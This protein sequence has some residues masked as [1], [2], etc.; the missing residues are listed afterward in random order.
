[1]GLCAST[2][3]T[4]EQIAKHQDD[5]AATKEIDENIQNDHQNAGDVHKL[6]LLGT[7]DS[8]KSTLFKQ[9]TDIFGKGFT[10]RQLDDAKSVVYSNTVN[11]M[12]QLCKGALQFSADKIECKELIQNFRKPHE[13]KDNAYRITPELAEQVKTVWKDPGIQD[14]F[15]RLK[16]NELNFELTCFACDYFFNKIDQMTDKDWLPSVDDLLRLRVMTTG[17]VQNDFMIEG[18]AFKMVDVGG[19]RNERKKWIHSFEDVTAVLFV[20]AI[21]EYDQVLY[22]DQATNRMVEALNV[23]EEVLQLRWFGKTSVMLFLNKSDLFLEKVG[24]TLIKDY[25]PEYT[26]PD[27]DY[28]AGIEFITKMFLAKDTRVK[29]EVDTNNMYAD[30]DVQLIYTHV[31]NAT[32]KK[33]VAYVFNTVKDIIISRSLA[34]AGLV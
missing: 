24:R 16:S 30:G 13:V 32:C 26:G 6:L 12:K 18:N 14:A 2:D 4:A 21:S 10:H 31:T 15:K 9:M 23:F 34:Q 20:V 22:E 1:M 28:D 29:K 33:T 8:G 27:Y 17:I 11:S 5:A 25:F 19:Q 7:G 3:M